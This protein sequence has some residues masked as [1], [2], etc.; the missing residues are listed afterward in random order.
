MRKGH[1]NF[2]S[3][4]QSEFCHFTV[5]RLQK[6][7]VPMKSRVPFGRTGIDI[8]IHTIFKIFFSGI[9]IKVKVYQVDL[10]PLAVSEHLFGIY[11][12]CRLFIQFQRL[13]TVLFQDSLLVLTCPLS[14]KLQID[15]LLMN[16]N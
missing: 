8:A 3:I 7:A 10:I 15:A 14:V 1:Y 9:T 13:C 12:P 4:E 6:F 16:H 11:Y 5:N 2:A